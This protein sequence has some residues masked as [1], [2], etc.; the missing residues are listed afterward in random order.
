MEDKNETKEEIIIDEEEAKKEFLEELK[1][2]NMEETQEIERAKILAALALSDS[3]ASEEI[4]L[5][6]AKSKKANH[7]KTKKSLLIKELKAS[8]IDTVVTGVLSVA[9]L[10]LFDLILRLLFGYYVA[11]LKGVYI[12]VFLIVLVI[13]TPIMNISKHGKTLGQKFS[14]TEA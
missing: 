8:L 10:F 11:D 1:T 13:Y 14:K 9:A 12:I 4:T 2:K 7:K 6:I 3:V 5:E